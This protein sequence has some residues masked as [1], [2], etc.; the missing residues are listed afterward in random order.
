ML[1][2]TSLNII[3]L[4]IKP[5]FMML[6]PEKKKDFS[7]QCLKVQEIAKKLN[8]VSD[9]MSLMAAYGQKNVILCLQNRQ[10]NKGAM[11]FFH[12]PKMA[13]QRKQNNSLLN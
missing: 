5:A 10:P 2:V 7:Q 3:R 1:I 8:K 12:S 4:V 6:V 13:N 9:L 11:V